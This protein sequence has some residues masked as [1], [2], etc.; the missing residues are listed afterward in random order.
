MLMSEAKNK[1]K[2]RTVKITIRDTN[3]KINKDHGKFVRVQGLSVLSSSDRF[4]WWTFG[5]ENFVYIWR[6]CMKKCALR[7]G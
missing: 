5:W 1:S 4:L 2:R 3:M 6:N 7:K